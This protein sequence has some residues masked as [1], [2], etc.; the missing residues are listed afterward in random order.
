MSKILKYDGRGD[1]TKHL[2]TYKT[3][4]S[5]RGVTLAAKYRAFHLTLNWADEVWYSRLSPGRIRSWPEF[6]T[7]FLKRFTVSK[8]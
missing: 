8:E 6:K 1:P 5:L 4:I 2:N 3:Y 7:I